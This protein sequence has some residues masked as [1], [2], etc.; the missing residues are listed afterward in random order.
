[1]ARVTDD[2]RLESVTAHRKRLRQALLLGH[3]DQRRDIDDGIGSVVASVVVGA[4][5]C[6]GCVGYSFV[7]HLLAQAQASSASVP[8]SSSSSVYVPPVSTPVIQPTDQYQPL[9]TTSP[10]GGS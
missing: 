2:V 6:A 5:V 3:T 8:I 7:T 9:I 4:V 10:T 1:M